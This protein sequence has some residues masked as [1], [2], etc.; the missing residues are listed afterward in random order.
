M[1]RFPSYCDTLASGTPHE[2][3]AVLA[4]LLEISN[5]CRACTEAQPD[6]LLEDPAARENAKPW[7]KFLDIVGQP[8]FDILLG[9]VAQE[10]PSEV[11]ELAGDIMAQLWHPCAVG[12][13]LEDFEQHRDTLTKKPPLRI[14][15]N[16]GGIGTVAAAKALMWMWGTRWDADV[17]NALGMCD[18]ET[19]QDF[20]LRQATEHS[21]VHVRLVCLMSL[22]APLT[23][24]KEA[25]LLDRL[26][27]GT[28]D[29][30]F[31]AIMK[32]E[33]LKATWAIPELMALHAAE[34]DFNF[35][36]FIGEA[37]VKL[38]EAAVTAG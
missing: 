12:R 17:V 22:S 37:L 30:R 1:K 23:T 27:Q 14:F 38:R 21:G 32:V 24:R 33:E 15:R 19:V 8:L 31:V 29:E 16:L 6:S 36:R 35:A 25:L 7:R 26:R 4:E 34:T 3:R 5:G 18:C 28:H 10:P 13:L 11:R 20:L 9:I 2:K